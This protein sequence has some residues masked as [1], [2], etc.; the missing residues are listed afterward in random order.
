MHYFV[1]RITE[2]FVVFFS[3]I[4]LSKNV[5]I[6]FSILWN[7]VTVCDCIGMVSVTSASCYVTLALHI[8]K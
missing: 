4:I 5:R 8:S 7:V 3:K 6:I 1:N 2:V